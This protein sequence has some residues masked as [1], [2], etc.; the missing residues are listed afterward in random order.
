MFVN[1]VILILQEL[2]EAALLISVLLV[3][4]RQLRPRWPGLQLRR[5]WV[6]WA[7]GCGGLG[8]WLYAGWMPVIA[9]IS[10]GSMTS[11]IRSA[12]MR[13]RSRA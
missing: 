4:T 6:L 3:V 7:L 2:L 9:A 5:Y 8:A 11:A 13:N 10:S 1:A 12:I